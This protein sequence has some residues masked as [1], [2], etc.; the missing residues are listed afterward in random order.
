MIAG[1]S[2]HPRRRATLR[3]PGCRG[4]TACTATR[5]R[6]C[7]PTPPCSMTLDVLVFDIQDVGAR[8]YTFVWTMVLAMRAVRRRRQ[9]AFVVLDRP[10]PI[11]GALVEGGAIA[12]GYDSFVGLVSCPN[13]HGLTAGEIAALARPRGAP[14]P[15][16]HR[17][18]SCAA[19]DRGITATPRPACRGSCRRPT[20]RRS[21]PRW[22]TPA[23][24][25]SRAPSCRRRAAPRGR[26]SWPA[27]PGSTPSAL[28][29]PLTSDGSCPGVRARPAVYT[30]HVPQ[31]RR[32]APA[33]GVQQHVVDAHA[34][35][36]YLTGVAFLKAC[37]DLRRPTA[38]PGGL[39]GLRV[40]R[41]PSRPSICCAAAA[42]VRQRHRRRGALPELAA[43]WAS[44]AEFT[45]RRATCSCTE[46]E[47]A[48]P[49]L[50]NR[51]PSSPRAC[52]ARDATTC[53]E[54]RRGRGVLGGSFNPPH[55]G[56]P[57]AR[58]VRARDHRAGRR[59]VAPADLPAS[60][61][62]RSWRPTTIDVA[63]CELVAAEPRAGGSRA[64][65]ARGRA[66]ARARAS[67]S[68]RT[69]DLLESTWPR[70]QPDAGAG[71]SSSAPTSWHEAH[72]AW[73]RWDDVVTPGAADR[74]RPGRRRAGDPRRDGRAP[75]RRCR[76][77]LVDARCAR[78]WPRGSG[79]GDLSGPSAARGDRL[80]RSSVSCIVGAP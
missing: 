60:R 59:A 1:R 24:A 37:R 39:Q 73:H 8:Y 11:G 23:C 33:A 20:C 35:R 65:R 67:S 80:Y 62:A 2:R 44:A 57:A 46:A 43:T 26:S 61:S 15:R 16:P 42:E 36:P 29:A 14:R 49:C 50:R 9:V 19:G 48:G 41:R 34:Y 32:S 56:P 52:R 66:G 45:R 22:C 64:S 40:R 10:N 76:R 68:S 77:G 54:M 51:R 31:A 55:V 53:L 75:G 13:R 4:A 47:A 70:D 25:W 17:R 21:T 6:R 30:A 27:R 79:D 78:C 28:A 58:A 3:V 72:A 5:S 69:H 7:T 71:A 38:S 63:M 12:P 18:S 74:R